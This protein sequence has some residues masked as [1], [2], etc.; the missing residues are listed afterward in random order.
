LLREYLPDFKLG[1][2]TQSNPAAAELLEF[3]RHGYQSN[4]TEN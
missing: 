2:P 1:R 4:C 3:E